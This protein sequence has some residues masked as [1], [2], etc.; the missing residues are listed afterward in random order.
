MP[1]TPPDGKDRGYPGRHFTLLVS[2]PP[3]GREAASLAYLFAREAWAGKCPVDAVFFYEDGVLNALKTVAPAS[4]EADL[5]ALWRELSR[6]T[7]MRLVLCSAAG[8]RRGAVAGSVAPDFE[9]GALSDLADLLLT[10]SRL[11]QFR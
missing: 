3:Y 1:V 8:E 9:I 11:V 6:D 10:G 7:G 4:G 2:G 5:P